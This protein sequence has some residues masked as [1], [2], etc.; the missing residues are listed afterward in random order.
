MG[1]G[2]IMNGSAKACCDAVVDYKTMYL[3]GLGSLTNRGG[4]D[5]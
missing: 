5:K 3:V 2:P 4:P 1:C